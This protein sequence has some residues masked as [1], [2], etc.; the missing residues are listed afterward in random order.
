[1]QCRNSNIGA[2]TESLQQLEQFIQET[3]EG[4]QT[5]LKSIDHVN[6]NTIIT[7]QDKINIKPTTKRVTKISALSVVL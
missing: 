1:M 7:D 4:I 6:I 2:A 5:K 3:I